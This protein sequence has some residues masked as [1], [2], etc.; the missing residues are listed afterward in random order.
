LVNFDLAVLTL[1]LDGSGTRIGRVD[2]CMD[3]IENRTIE[4]DVNVGRGNSLGL[5]HGDGCDGCFLIYVG[6]G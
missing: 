6:G 3:R 1:G 4:D 5:W 2:G